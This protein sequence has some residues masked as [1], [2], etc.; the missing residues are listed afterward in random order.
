MFNYVDTENNLE[1]RQIS[2]AGIDP[3]RAQLILPARS[4]LSSPQ[5]RHFSTQHTPVTRGTAVLQRNC[6][7]AT[8]SSAPSAPLC[9]GTLAAPP[10]RCRLPLAGRRER[11]F[12]PAGGARSPA[13]PLSPHAGSPGGGSAR[14]AAHPPRTGPGSGLGRGLGPRPGPGFGRGPCG[15]APGQRQPSGGPGR[16]H[17]S[18]G[19]LAPPTLP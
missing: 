13:P 14:S 15:A 4:S 12:S 10:R 8:L 17:H 11:L 2:L 9:A 1:N 7:T 19:R 3:A 6:G 5:L 18:N 16:G